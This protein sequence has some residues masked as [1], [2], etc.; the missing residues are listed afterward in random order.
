[1]RPSNSRLRPAD[2]TGPRYFSKGIQMVTVIIVIAAVLV[3]LAALK[4]IVN[5]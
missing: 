4:F 3:G 5:R 1:M 2:G